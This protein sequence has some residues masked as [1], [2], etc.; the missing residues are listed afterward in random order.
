MKTFKLLTLA[1]LIA[2]ASG[3][4]VPASR[5][6]PAAYNLIYVD[7]SRS[8]E[9]AVMSVE[10]IGRV[11]SLLDS[12]GT[13]KSAVSFY[14]SNDT[15][16]D[17]ASTTG[18]AKTLINRMMNSYSAPPNSW[19]D[20]RKLNDVLANDKSLTS[21]TSVNLYLFLS[22]NYLKG[23][24]LGN[25]NGVLLNFLPR[26]VQLYSSLPDERINV[27]VFYPQKSQTAFTE[28]IRAF[29]AFSNQ[30]DFKSGIQYHFSSL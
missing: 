23:D 1:P 6:A 25:N 20:R 22:E 15:R 5:P 21:A 8:S 24:L 3:F 11:E 12:I 4:V 7:N 2:A 13:A 10:M 29:R 28:R 26:E 27:F 16:P 17:M 30:K 14:L 9:D 19:R 18:T